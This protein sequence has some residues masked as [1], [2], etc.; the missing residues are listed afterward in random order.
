ML[1][2]LTYRRERF[3]VWKILPFLYVCTPYWKHLPKY[4]LALHFSEDE[5]D[6]H[7]AVVI[8]VESANRS[9]MCIEVL[10]SLT[11]CIHA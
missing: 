4:S 11:R 1:S 9:N 6:I 8:G 10:W 3:V 7:V 5:L 2:L